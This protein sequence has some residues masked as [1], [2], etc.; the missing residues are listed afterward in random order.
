MNGGNGVVSEAD[1]RGPLRPFFVKVAGERADELSI[2]YIGMQGGRDRR[3]NDAAKALD[4]ARREAK[5]GGLQKREAIKCVF[6]FSFFF[7][8]SSS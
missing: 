2:F 5:V 1:W 8:C 7:F 4:Q 3:H 6:F